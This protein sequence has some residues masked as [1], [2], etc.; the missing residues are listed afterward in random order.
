MSSVRYFF[1]E[2]DVIFFLTVGDKVADVW[3]TGEGAAAFLNYQV[4][5]GLQNI[6]TDVAVVPATLNVAWPAT[7]FPGFEAI[8][9]GNGFLSLVNPGVVFYGVSGNAGTY[10]TSFICDTVTVLS[11]NAIKITFLADPLPPPPASYTGVYDLYLSD[12]TIYANPN[13]LVISNALTLV[14]EESGSAGNE[15]QPMYGDADAPTADPSDT[16]KPAFYRGR[17]HNTLW[18]WDT[19]ELAWFPVANV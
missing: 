6:V 17:T 4:Q 7:T 8:I 5:L 2:G 11:N 19:E 13:E 16:S 18:M 14:N 3:P 10:D 12:N 9:V 15:M 1:L